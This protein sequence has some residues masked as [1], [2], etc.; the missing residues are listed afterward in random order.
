M[1]IYALVLSCIVI[2]GVLASCGG[3]S[4]T[5]VLG[6]KPIPS[7]YQ[8][9]SIEQLKSKSSNIPYSD[10]IGIDSGEVITRSNDPKIAESI[11]NHKVELVISTVTLNKSRG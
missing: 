3:G 4:S 8:G 7:K 1:R 10:I 9:L 6:P 11:M 5:V 2:S